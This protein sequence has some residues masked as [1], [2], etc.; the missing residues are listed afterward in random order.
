[1][2]ILILILVIAWCYFSAY[3]VSLY[4]LAVYIDPEDIAELIPDASE[5]HRQTLTRLVDDPRAFVQVASVYRSFVLVVIAVC[6][7]FLTDRIVVGSN[8]LYS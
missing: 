8:P 2:D 5:R 7:V 3:V 6:V 4:A 1:M